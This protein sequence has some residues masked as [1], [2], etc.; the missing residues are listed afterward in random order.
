[1]PGPTGHPTDTKIIWTC[2]FSQS[3]ELSRYLC[4]ALPTFCIPANVLPVLDT[5]FPYQVVLKV[6]L[7]FF[8]LEFLFLNVS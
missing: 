2:L 7:G 6:G 3:V 5:S 4:V 8:Y 1:M